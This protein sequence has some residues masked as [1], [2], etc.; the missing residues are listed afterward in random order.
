MSARVAL[1]G[2]F[3]ADLTFHAPRLP[4]LGETVLAEGFTLG[5]GG[6]GSNQAIAAARAGAEATLITRVGDDAFADLAFA[7]WASA[8]VDTRF[9][10]RAP[11]EATGAAFIYV[12]P[13]SGQN[14]IVVNP[15][16]AGALS[17]ED[18]RR[19]HAA[20]EGAGAFV[21]QLE[22]PLEAAHAALALARATL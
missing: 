3:A 2:I 16:A 6:K 9:V 10:T 11:G 20:I 8:G 13:T 21:V 4:K 22:Q 15:A 1:L 7:E 12:D 14:A 18:V 17:P 5:A 19:A